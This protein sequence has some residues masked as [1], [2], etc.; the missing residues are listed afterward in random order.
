MS[1]DL[2]TLARYGAQTRIAQLQREIEELRRA[3]PDLDGKKNGHRLTVQAEAARIRKR[4]PM[5]AAQKKAV[6]ERMRHY[7]RT[8]RMA[9]HTVEA[10]EQAQPAPPTR[11]ISEAGRARIAAAQRKRWRAVKRAGKK[12]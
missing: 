6:G 8:R 11:V 7:W 1:I 4:K 9:S 2:N 3:F 12:R 10:G 5:T